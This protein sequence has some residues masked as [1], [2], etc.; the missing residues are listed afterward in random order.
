MLIAGGATRASTCRRSPTRPDHVRAVVAIGEAAAEV[1]AAFRT[2]VPGD[3]AASMDEAVA[4]AARRPRAG[5]AV[6]L[7]PGCASFDWYRS[8]AERGDD[9]AA[10]SA[11]WWAAD[12]DE[13]GDPTE[14]D[15]EHG[16]AASSIGARR[17]VRP[18]VRAPPRSR[19]ASSL[20]LAIVVVLNLIGLVMV[21]S[22]SS[23]IAL[24]DY[25]SSW[26]F[27]NRQAIWTALGFAALFVDTARRLP[28]L[29]QAHVRSLC[30]LASRSS[31]SC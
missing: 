20:L 31:S 10:P 9:F 27:F 30:S 15:G 18:V 16:G 23:V 6:L 12:G 26:T 13:D 19:G 5:D 4:A 21:L 14:V 24:H 11:S 28:P 17:A 8:Y 29:A 2:R 22:A 25:G 7:S 1:A 3:R